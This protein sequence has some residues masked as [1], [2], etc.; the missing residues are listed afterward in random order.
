MTICFWFRKF[1][2]TASGTLL[3]YGASNKEIKIHINSSSPYNIE[4]KVG[5]ATVESMFS[6][7]DGIDE[8]TD[9]ASGDWNH[10]AL[11]ILP[12]KNYNNTIKNV[13][14]FVNGVDQTIIT[15]SDTL[16]ETTM[17]TSDNDEIFLLGRVRS[18]NEYFNGWIDDFRIYD[19]ALSP[20]ELF[21][22][23]YN[24]YNYKTI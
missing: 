21:E 3:N 19:T 4:A 11:V 7:L 20:S 13:R 24:I 5:S 6:T 14:I 15:S 23:H 17:N 12:G 16:Y 22:L 10:L 8:T 2:S 1:K 9:D 18:G